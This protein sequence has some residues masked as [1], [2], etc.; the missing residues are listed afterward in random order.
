M[1][2]LYLKTHSEINLLMFITYFLSYFMYGHIIDK[3]VS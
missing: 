3:K 2:I 1:K